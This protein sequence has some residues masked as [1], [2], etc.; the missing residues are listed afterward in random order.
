MESLPN[1][2]LNKIYSFVGQH[3]IAKLYHEEVEVLDYKICNYDMALYEG[4][5]YI[6]SE[7]R[8]RLYQ[9]KFRNY[10]SLLEEL[11][12]EIRLY[13]YDYVDD[14]DDDETKVVFSKYKASFT[15]IAHIQSFADYYF[16]YLN[17]RIY[18]QKKR[19]KKKNM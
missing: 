18:K 14:D 1:E 8:L 16:Y 13:E 3:P 17:K 4:G 5:K 10:I 15:R 7:K 6:L 11:E 9:S 2:I 12:C 19:K